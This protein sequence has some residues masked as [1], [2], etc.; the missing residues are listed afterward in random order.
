MQVEVDYVN[1]LL[2]PL[3]NA[4]TQR[5]AQKMFAQNY[6]NTVVMFSK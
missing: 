6:A 3:Y 4:E 1:G 2:S 5:A